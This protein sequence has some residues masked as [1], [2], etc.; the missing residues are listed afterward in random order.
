MPIGAYR[1]RCLLMN[2]TGISPDGYGGYTA[3]YAPA[4]P[5]ELDASIQA[6][7][8][9]D[10]ERA[11]A[12]T[13]LGTA[14]HL[15]RCRYRPDVS[16]A[17]RLQFEGRLFEV[18]SVQN[19]DERDIALILICAEILGAEAPA[20]ARVPRPPSRDNF[21]AVKGNGRNS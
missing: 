21:V 16:Q 15:I 17:S 19:V 20:H 9:R 12:G 7:N 3:A 1:H 2:P 4:N 14:T 10:L 13:V 11:T 18:Q 5:P 8:A 6:A